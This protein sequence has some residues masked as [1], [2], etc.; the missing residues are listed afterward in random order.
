MDL[1]CRSGMLGNNAAKSL[2]IRLLM[3]LLTGTHR[4]RCLSFQKTQ[5]PVLASS[6]RYCSFQLLFGTVIIVLKHYSDGMQLIGICLG[7]RSRAPPFETMCAEYD[8]RRARLRKK[9]CLDYIH[10]LL[11]RSA[12]WELVSTQ[13]TLSL[14]SSFP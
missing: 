14:S 6:R 2:T 13:N 8:Q 7:Q 9:L 10:S 11:T 4:V 12:F 1:L 5:I 3:V